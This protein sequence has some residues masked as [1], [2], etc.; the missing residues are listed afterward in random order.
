MPRIRSHKQIN[1]VV[2][3]DETNAINPSKSSSFISNCIALQ[4]ESPSRTN[5]ALN[6][7]SNEVT[8][9]VIRYL[10]NGSSPRATGQDR[11]GDARD[12]WLATPAL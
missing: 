6:F 5:E 10:G 1:T 9:Y 2:Y 4:I 7:L 11:H 12:V 8:R 3:S